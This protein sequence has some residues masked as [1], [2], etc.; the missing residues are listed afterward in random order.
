MTVPAQPLPLKLV[1]YKAKSTP[2]ELDNL[3]FGGGVELC[4]T[5]VMRGFTGDRPH[6]AL[7][8]IVNPAQLQ[9]ESMLSHAVQE[10]RGRCGTPDLVWIHTVCLHVTKVVEATSMLVTQMSLIATRTRHVSVM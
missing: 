7:V 8:I 9:L 1:S 3:P 6:R 5:R 2:V 4:G 10:Q